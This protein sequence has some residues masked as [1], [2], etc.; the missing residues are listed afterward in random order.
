MSG[1]EEVLKILVECFNRIDKK[2]DIII[3]QNEKILNSQGKPLR[4]N[5]SSFSSILDKELKVAPDALT[6]LSLPTSLRKTIV[7]LYQLGEVTAEDIAKN[8]NRMR[9][10]ESAHANDLVRLGF[11]K[12]RRKG[13]KVYFHIE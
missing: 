8:T 13:R 3:K 12:K 6:L 10:V 11:V 1:L 5:K 4:G 9:A 7:A 2:L